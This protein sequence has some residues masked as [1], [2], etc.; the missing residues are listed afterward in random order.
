MDEVKKIIIAELDG[1]VN[2]LENAEGCSREDVSE[3]IY[4]R[5]LRIRRILESR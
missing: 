2:W 4:E 3:G 1:I 5:V